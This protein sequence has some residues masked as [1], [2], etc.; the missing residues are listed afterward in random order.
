MSNEFEKVKLQL[1]VRCEDC[2]WFDEGFDWKMMN[3]VRPVSCEKGGLLLKPCS[4]FL[5][6]TDVC[7]DQEESNEEVL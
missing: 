6:T 7:E 3:W 4:E 1:P 5:R 2:I